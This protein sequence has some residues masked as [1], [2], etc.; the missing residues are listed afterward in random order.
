MKKTTV[1]LPDELRSQLKRAA[2][3]RGVSEATVI[4]DAIRKAVSDDRPA[5]RG[6]LFEGKEQIANRAEELLTGFGER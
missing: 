1:Y 6:G 3:L 4:R 5:P 2:K